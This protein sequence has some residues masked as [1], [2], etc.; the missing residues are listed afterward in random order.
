MREI[1]VIVAELITEGD[2]VYLQPS[3]YRL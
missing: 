3:C 2:L 1:I